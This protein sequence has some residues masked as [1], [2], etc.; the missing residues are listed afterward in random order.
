MIDNPINT[1][2]LT[3]KRWNGFLCSETQNLETECCNQYS[4]REV[5]DIHPHMNTGLETKSKDS[6][7][8]DGLF[9]VPTTQ[10]AALIAHVGQPNLRFW[11]LYKK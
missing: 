7:R 6:S 8:A 4:H 10:R 1:V 2:M 9:G 5:S 3:E 11:L